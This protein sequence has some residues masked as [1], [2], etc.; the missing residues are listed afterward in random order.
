MNTSFIQFDKTASYIPGVSTIVNL[1]EIMY[2]LFTMNQLDEKSL[3]SDSVK[4]YLSEKSFIRCIILLIPILGNLAILASDLIELVRNRQNK[5]PTTAP[6][7]PVVLPEEEIHQLMEEREK[8]EAEF[9]E[10]VPLAREI[11]KNEAKILAPKLEYTINVLSN[12][13]NSVN[14]TTDQCDLVTKKIIDFS[15]KDDDY[16]GKVI[17]TIALASI[18][19]MGSGLT[20]MGLC[21]SAIGV[22]VWSFFRA[23]S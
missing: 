5:A 23:G 22:K 14:T 12:L 8:V 3:Q 20:V 16:L 15:G 1:P 2:K 6:S 7:E 21:R 18:V 4:S 13:T 10:V 17:D 9:H 19:Y 11:L